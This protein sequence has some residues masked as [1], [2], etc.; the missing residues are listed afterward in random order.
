MKKNNNNAHS[1]KWVIDNNRSNLQLHA[2]RNSNVIVAEYVHEPLD[3]S[4]ILEHQLIPADDNTTTKEEV[5]DEKE[6]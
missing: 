2:K 5:T 3:V 1:I 6:E 4:D